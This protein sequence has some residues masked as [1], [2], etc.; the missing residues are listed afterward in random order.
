MNT[1]PIRFIDMVR[2]SRHFRN[3]CLAPDL[4]VTGVSY[5]VVWSIEAKTYRRHLSSKLS[6]CSGVSCKGR[7]E[8][9]KER[10]DVNKW[11]PCVPPVYQPE[12]QSRE[13]YA[14]SS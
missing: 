13:L 1:E 9:D 8:C 6:V 4:L 10:G 7:L 2:T 11:R 5:G 12:H 14:G 3:V